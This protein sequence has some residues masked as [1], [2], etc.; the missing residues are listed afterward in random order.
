MKQEV[1]SKKIFLR[2]FGWP[3]VTV[4]RDGA[5]D[6]EEDKC[7]RVK[8]LGKKGLENRNVFNVV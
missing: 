3:M 1:T 6:S 8:E 7:F 2:T 5:G 4:A